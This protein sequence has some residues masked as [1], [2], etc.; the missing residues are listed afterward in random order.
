MA[1]NINELKLNGGLLLVWMNGSYGTLFGLGYKW[2]DKMQ[3]LFENSLKIIQMVCYVLWV[4]I[5]SHLI[6]CWVWWH[7]W[8]WNGRLR[9]WN[10]IGRLCCQFLWGSWLLLQ[11]RAANRCNILIW[12]TIDVVAMVNAMVWI[13]YQ[14]YCRVRI[15]VFNNNRFMFI[16]CRAADWIKIEMEKK[17][18]LNWCQKT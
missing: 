1:K 15:F 18:Q 9:Q 7:R 5:K 16:L 14:I 11:S 17:L 2:I 8:Q 13:W 12:M 10:A 6:L 4:E 3:L